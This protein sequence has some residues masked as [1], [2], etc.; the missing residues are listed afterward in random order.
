MIKS[1]KIKFIKHFGSLKPESSY[2]NKKFSLWLS[3]KKILLSFLL[4]YILD[5]V[6]ISG[7]KY[8]SLE[9]YLKGRKKLFFTHSF[10]YN[11]YLKLNG[12][13]KNKDNIVYLDQNFTNHPA[14]EINKTKPITNKSF[15][16]K[17]ENYLIKT[18]K[19]N[20]CE[21]KIALHPSAEKKIANF[22]K[23]FKCYFDKTAE[24]VRD[25]RFVVAHYT[26]AIA[27]PVL[28]NKPITFLTSEELIS[29]RPGNLT[30]DLSKE[31][32][33][34][35]I[36]I[37]KGDMLTLNKKIN[38]KKYKDLINNYIKHPKSKNKDTWL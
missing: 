1:H 5:I 22:S 31:L 10:D 20:K 16:Y 27:Y 14:F 28:L 30:K 34:K 21:V 35:L 23:K 37:D 32:G 9:I 6:L 4:R 36:N 2:I 26:T 3:L 19:A 12:A 33:S 38:K 17:L 8:K 24:L 29:K 15:Y 25:S 18:S 13:N 7:L 11:S